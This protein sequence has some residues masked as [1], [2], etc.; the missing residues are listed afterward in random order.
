MD[1]W[2]ETEEFDELD[3]AG[4]KGWVPVLIAV[5]L[6]LLIAGAGLG[7]KLYDK[8]SYS[9][10]E[11]D[12]YEYYSVGQDWETALIVQDEIIEEKAVCRDGNFYLPLSFVQDHLND[13]FY[14]DRH[15]KLLL[16][17]TPTELYEIPPE[18]C[19]YMISG[20]PQENEKVIWILQGED[21]YVELDFVSQYADFLSE[22]YGQPNRIQLYIQGQTSQTASIKKDTAV[23][24]QGGI[25]SDILKPLVKGDKVYVLEEME[26]WSKVKTEDSVIGYVEN[27]RLENYAEEEIG[28]PG[29]YVAP[30]YASIQKDYVINMA[31]HQ[32]TNAVANSGIE[33][34]L[35]NTK[36]LNT[37]SPTWFFLSDNLGGFVSIADQSYVDSMHARGIEVWAL[38][39]NFTNDVDIAQ[40][41][42]T[43]T[44]R[45][46]LINNLV[47]TT[48]AYGIDGINVDFE[49]VPME[50][51]ED[52]VQF[53]RE[54]S[55]PCRQNGI[56]LSV[57][58]YVPTDYT[59]HY[60]RKEQGEV[61]DYFVIMGYDEHYSGSSQAGSVASLGYVKAGIENTL[62]DVP[63]HKVING[64][65]SYTRLWKIS[66]GVSSEALSMAVAENYLA[67]NGVTAVWDQ[68][69]AQ[70]F[71]S[72][73]ADGATYQIW[74]EDT[75]SV[76]AKLNLMS[77][78]N[79]AGVAQWKLGLEKAEIWDVIAEYT[80]KAQMSTQTSE[81]PVIVTD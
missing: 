76:R 46:N 24:Y 32:V 78:Y 10:E 28:L 23:R 40:I 52:Y 65:P 60:G 18:S 21:P 19:S 20:Q 31:W 7:A 79:L 29:T 34:M 72:F 39:D 66:D 4:K 70:N 12:L 1:D 56:V 13:K 14:Y 61:I 43:T 11:M 38:V 47:Q 77:G 36:G 37:I 73:E 22:I 51:G 62:R 75:E 2:D 59:A 3:R 49:Q 53:L 26:T 67:Q 9:K 64:I 44:N 69:T 41:L 81:L 68:E 6:I 17:T 42:S 74:L 80:S 54:L 5:V 30:V 48:L 45:K 33:A 71:A 63:A 27:K 55:I 8:Y 25:K 15:E 35:A 57:D 50:A 16:F 58:N